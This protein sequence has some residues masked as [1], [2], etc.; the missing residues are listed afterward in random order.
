MAEMLKVRE[1]A[2]RARVSEKTMRAWIKA[3]KVP[4]SKVGRAWLIS[5]ARLLQ[6]LEGGCA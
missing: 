6:V 4:A 5:E 1:A 3:G 2:K